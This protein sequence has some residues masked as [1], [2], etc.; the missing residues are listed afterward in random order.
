VHSRY[1]ISG[2]AWTADY[3]G[4]PRKCTSHLK[5]RWSTRAA[6]AKPRAA[7]SWAALQAE[8]RAS[9]SRTRVAW[10][11]GRSRWRG[12]ASAAV[13]SLSEPAARAFGVFPL[14]T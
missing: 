3:R 10:D 6:R 2:T 7:E 8:S 9:R 1:D 11:Q 4:S 5:Y 13:P 12:P 14:A